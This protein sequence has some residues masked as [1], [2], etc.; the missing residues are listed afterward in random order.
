VA[1][2]PGAAPRAAEV[3]SDH[4][5]FALRQRIRAW[6]AE[7]GH[8]VR[9]HGCGGPEPCDYPDY[10]FAVARAVAATPGAFGVLVCGSGIGMSIVANKVPGVR[11][12]LC[13]TPEMARQSRRHNDANVIVLGA[14]LAAPEENLRI[15]EAWL[16]ATFEGGRHARRVEKIVRGECPGAGGEE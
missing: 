11:A 2:G 4:R 1:A 12:A 9:D 7:R 13:V 10:A 15:L 5:G 14:D 16:G 8:P 3:G 6:L